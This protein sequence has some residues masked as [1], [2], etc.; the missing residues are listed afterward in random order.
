MISTKLRFVAEEK[1]RD[2]TSSVQDKNIP[3]VISASIPSNATTVFVPNRIP[4]FQLF[5]TACRLEL[6]DSCAANGCM[7]HDSVSSWNVVIK[8]HD[9]LFSLPKTAKYAS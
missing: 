6:L 3:W 1:P 8:W 4:T 7:M 5:L 9:T 2:L